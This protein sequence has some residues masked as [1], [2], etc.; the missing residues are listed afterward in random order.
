MVRV[1]ID[2]RYC[3]L[4][5][6][7]KLPDSVFTFDEELL[8]SP[9]RARTGR[10]VEFSLP[11][12]P[13]NDSI[14]GFAADPYAAERFNASYHEGVVEV[15]GVALLAG[16]VYLCGVESAPAADGGECRAVSYRIAITGGAAE[17]AKRA[18]ERKIGATRLDYSES[19]DGAAIERSWEEQSAVKFLPVYRDEYLMSEDESSLYAP[20]RVLTV[21]DYHPFISVVSLLDEIFT[22]AGYSVRSNF[23]QGDLARSLHISGKVDSGSTASA[24]RLLSLMGFM[25]GRRDEADAVADYAGRVYLSPLVLANSLGNIVQTTDK[26]VDECFYNNGNA[27]TINDEG[28]TY[29]PRTRANVAFEIFLKYTTDCRILSRERLQGFDTIYV[30]TGC[31]MHFNI[32]NPYRDHRSELTGFLEYLCVVFDFSMGEQYRIRWQSASGTSYSY[33]SERATNVTSPSGVRS[34]QLMR[35]SSSGVW[36]D[37]DDDW[38]LYDG[39][40]EER[41]QHE[42]EITIRTMPEELSPS[43][44]K[45]FG[46]MYIE[47]AEAGQRITL[48]TECR[49]QPLFSASLGYGS[50]VDGLT[51]LQ[52]DF[53]QAQLIEAVQQMFNLRIVTHQPS[54]TVWIEPRDDHYTDA[55]YDWTDRVVLT[56]PMVATDMAAEVGS[57]RTLAYRAE[58]GGAV[59]RFNAVNGDNPLGEWSLNTDSYIAIDKDDRQLNTLFCPTLSTTA[60][61]ADAPSAALISMGDR[62]VDELGESAVRVVSYRGMQP[63]PEGQHWGFP[64]DGGSYPFAAFHYV[65]GA[66]AES[67]AAMSGGVAAA[68]PDESFTLC[69][70]NRD[71]VEGLNRYYARQWRGETFRRKLSV[72]IRLDADELVALC[73]IGDDH[74]DIRSLYEFEFSGQRALYRLV[75]IEGYD[76]ERRVARMTFAREDHD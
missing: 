6:G 47:G 40:L 32:A 43:R 11:A 57:V 2:D 72:A 51:V 68:G 25:A 56:E 13:D 76:A 52:H 71:G 16:V 59:A 70:E 22:E 48:S 58:G 36:V 8:I 65:V 31:Q 3:D 67:G 74:P 41:T 1:K 50:Q 45:S 4:P 7:F 64:S 33:I 55:R 26:S 73:D 69:Y 62:D 28:I 35:L 30:D 61:M 15:D 53:S 66:T 19:L 10:R 42:V 17:W 60:V 5:E 34:C 27:L 46:R 18:A 23:L 38:A 12:S 39:Y 37:C 21:G 20:Q 14:V 9:Q 29:K 63:L 44:S 49:M 54:R 24:S 75:G